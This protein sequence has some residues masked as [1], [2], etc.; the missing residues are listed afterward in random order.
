MAALRQRLAVGVLTASLAGLAFITSGEKREYQAY[1][2]PALGWKVPTICDGHTGPDVYRGQRANDQM[3][4][5]WR[6][7]DAEVS[8]KAI[9]RCSG[10]AKLTQHEFDA[11]VS[12]VHNIG[13]TAYCG[14]TMSRLIREGKL[15]QVPGQFDRW[16]Y[17]GGRKLRGLVNRR[18]SERNL[19]ERGDYGT[20]R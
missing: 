19:W 16:V 9:R 6:A 15:D 1:A 2:D 7:K 13:P 17:S 4:D 3:C 11:L 18:Q 8:I 5:A 20:V 10:D 12:L 14:S